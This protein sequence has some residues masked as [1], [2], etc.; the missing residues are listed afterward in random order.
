MISSSGQKVPV[1]F[2][3]GISETR[4]KCTSIRVC[5]LQGSVA[6]LECTWYVRRVWSCAVRV[7]PTPHSPSH[8]WIY[9]ILT[10]ACSCPL[11]FSPEIFG[12]KNQASLGV[13]AA[14]PFSTDLVGG[15]VTVRRS[16][17]ELL[18]HLPHPTELYQELEVILFVFFIMVYYKILNSPLCYTIAPYCLS[19][20]YVCLHLMI[21]DSQSFPPP[22]NLKFVV[23][24]F[25]RYIH[26]CC[27][28][29]SFWLSIWALVF[30][31]P[32]CGPELSKRKGVSPGQKGHRLYTGEGRIF[33][34]LCG[35]NEWSLRCADSWRFLGLF[36]PPGT[37]LGAGQTLGQILTMSFK[38]RNIW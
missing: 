24:L 14:S 25:L 36:P 18:L 6:C 4:V 5:S 17:Y 33:F 21:P 26:L 2:S 29:E 11:T 31:P 37:L 15:G 9:N 3:W 27:I 32:A 16:G 28:L 20:L 10:V 30:R 7:P 34:S 23:F 35:Q 13:G 1:H 38:T 8:T 19:I 12:A 22:G